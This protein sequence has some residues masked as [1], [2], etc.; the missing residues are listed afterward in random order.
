LRRRGFITLLGAGAVTWP[1]TV[2][3]QQPAMPVIGY[4]SGGSA[5]DERPREISGLIRGLSETGYIEG[6]NVTIEYRWSEGHKDSTAVDGGR[7]RSTSSSCD[8]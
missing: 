7:L 4:L 8:R 5:V 2:R 6:Q 3:A 1:L